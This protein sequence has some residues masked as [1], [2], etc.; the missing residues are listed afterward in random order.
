MVLETY[1]LAVEAGTAGFI[2][3]VFRVLI[4]MFDSL[5][6]GMKIKKINLLLTLIVSGIAGIVAGV[7]FTNNL[8]V[9]VLAGFAGIHIVNEIATKV[10]AKGFKRKQE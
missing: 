7:F 5:S 2:G 4:G 9:A 1:I 6:Y 10:K 3:G 8:G